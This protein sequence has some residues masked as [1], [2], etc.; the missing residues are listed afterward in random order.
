[1]YNLKF[2]KQGEKGY[3]YTSI[4]G[5]EIEDAI[6]EVEEFIWKRGDIIEAHIEEKIYKTKKVWSYKQEENK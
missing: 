4:T 1:M 2:K 3:W 6:K 5:K